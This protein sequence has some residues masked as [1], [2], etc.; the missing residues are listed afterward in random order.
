MKILG[1]SFKGERRVY[2]IYKNL[3]TV[4]IMGMKYSA[5]VSQNTGCG[6]NGE[7]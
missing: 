3:T 6:E 1:Y 7:N 2:Q 4:Q 5:D